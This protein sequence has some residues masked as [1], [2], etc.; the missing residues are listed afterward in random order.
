MSSPPP[1]SVFR[2][3]PLISLVREREAAP[4]VLQMSYGHVPVAT[5]EALY[6]WRELVFFFLLH[7]Q[8][9]IVSVSCYSKVL[10]V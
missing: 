2:L 3:W 10:K 1:G 6:C 5:R 4:T 9:A 8:D 7:R